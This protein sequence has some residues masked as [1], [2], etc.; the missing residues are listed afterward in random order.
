MKGV[1]AHPALDSFGNLYSLLPTIVL[2]SSY[3]MA[4]QVLNSPMAIPTLVNS[5]I[6]LWTS[7]EEIVVNLDLRRQFDAC[8]V[9]MLRVYLHMTSDYALLV[10]LVR[11]ATVSSSR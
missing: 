11:S 1:D 6:L 2:L 9:S 10:Y 7:Y 8:S 5:A 4:P 3:L